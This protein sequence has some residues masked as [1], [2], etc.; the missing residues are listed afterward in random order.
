[1][2]SCLKFTFSAH[3]AKFNHNFYQHRRHKMVF[4]ERAFNI[5]ASELIDKL[6]V[7]SVFEKQN[8]VFR[9]I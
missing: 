2:N 5:L 7:S 3:F 6:F 9:E 1:M 4:M 8:A